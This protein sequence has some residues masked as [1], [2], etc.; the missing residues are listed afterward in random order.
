MLFRSFQGFQGPIKNSPLA[1]GIGAT[2]GKANIEFFHGTI[3]EVRISKS[4]RFDKD[5]T[6]TNRFETDANTLALY[7][8]DEGGG[9]VLKDSSGNAHHAKIVGA[10][11]V[12][13]DSRPLNVATSTSGFALEFA[14][15]Q[16]QVVFDGLAVHQ[17]GM[18]W[19][20]WITPKERRDMALMAMPTNDDQRGLQRVYLWKNGVAAV[21]VAQKNKAIGFT[22]SNSLPA[23]I[24]RAHV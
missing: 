10:K 6:P 18:T 3:D 14:G 1:F 23:K 4:V 24:G 8:F 12:T 15:D 9:D 2:P 22:A 11:W 7:H 20:G 19:E 17:N 21:R 16:D 13:V 5:F